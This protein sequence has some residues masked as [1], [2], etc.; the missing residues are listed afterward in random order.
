[1][2]HVHCE[3]QRTIHA[4]RYNSCNFRYSSRVLD[5]GRT[6]DIITDTIDFMRTERKGRHL[7]TLEK[8]HIYKIIRNSLHMNDTNIEAQ[9]R[10]FQR[11]HELYDRL[12]YTR[13]LERYLSENSHTKSVQGSQINK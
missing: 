1:M 2:K 12:Q 13:Y 7:K 10:I 4:I 3:I 5:T 11:V 9:N 8:Y 6:Y